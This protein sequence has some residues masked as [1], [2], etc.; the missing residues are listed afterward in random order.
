[1]FVATGLSDVPGGA[2]PEEDE[3]IEIVPWP[4]SDLDGASPRRSIARR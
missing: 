2:E 3:H 1:M 4:L